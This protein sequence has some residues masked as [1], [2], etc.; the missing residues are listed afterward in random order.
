MFVS[1]KSFLLVNYRSVKGVVKSDDVMSQIVSNKLQ[2]TDAVEYVMT[3]SF[4]TV[5]MLIY[6]WSINSNWVGKYVTIR[7]MAIGIFKG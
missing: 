2:P 3:Q 1:L 4:K 6:A 7:A 5:R